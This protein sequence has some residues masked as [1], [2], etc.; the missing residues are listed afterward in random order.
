MLTNE[1]DT[2]ISFGSGTARGTILDLSGNVV[3]SPT[4]SLADVGIGV[5]LAPGTSMELPAVVSTASCDPQLGYTLPAGDYQLVAEVQHSDGDT[6]T[7][8]S[9]P[10]P[11]VV[12][13]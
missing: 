2:P 1:G 9:P 3:S 7:L 8:H 5:D 6:T 12:G 13:G 11:I 10:I 4:Y